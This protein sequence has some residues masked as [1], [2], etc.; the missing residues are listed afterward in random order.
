VIIEKGF[1]QGSDEWN[2]ARNPSIGG[3]GIDNI[4]TPSGERSKSRDKYLIEK[5]SA[6]ISGKT[7]PI[8]QTF[9]MKWGH[10]YEP[11]ARDI[12]S[13]MFFI[14]IETCA[15]MW[16]DDL[17][18][19]H[20]SPDGYALISNPFGIEIKCYQ[21]PHFLEVKEKNEVPRIHFLQIQKGLAITGWDKWYFMC[22]FPNLEPIIIPV[23]RDEKLIRIIKIEE[24]LFIEDLDA[25][26]KKLKRE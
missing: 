19:S 16:A 1:V 17:K 7:K 6:I 26:V 10:E 23:E 22:Y 3:T 12:F 15:M 8:F 4:I 20:V 25:L 9:E 11:I 18:R 13:E 24:A 5:A 2:E 14:D 21:L